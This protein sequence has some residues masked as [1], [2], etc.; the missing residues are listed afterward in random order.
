MVAV[1]QLRESTEAD[2]VNALIDAGLKAGNRTQHTNDQVAA[3]LVVRTDPAAGT[4]V[5]R[6]TRIDYVLSL[7]PVV[8]PSATPQASPKPTPKTDPQAD[9]AADPQADAQADRQADTETDAQADG[10]PHPQAHA[11]T[12]ADAHQLRR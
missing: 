11:V 1:P 3:G 4:I 10:G 9:G 2:A 6:G 8:V 5:Q 12:H 7:G